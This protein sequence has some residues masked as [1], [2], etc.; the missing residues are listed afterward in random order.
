MPMNPS[1]SRCK[2]ISCAASSGDSSA[3]LMV[4]S[5]SFGCFIGIGDAGELFENSGAGFGIKTF[6]VALLAGLDRRGD[7]HQDESAHRIDQG[8]HVLAGCIVGGDG[9]ADGDASVLGDLRGDVPDAADVDVAMLFGEAQFGRKMLA[10]QI[11]IEQR[12]R[13]AAGFEK[14]GHQHIGDG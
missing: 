9:S 13:A 8:A 12:D 4:T 2:M 14:F 10:H 3:V 7:V 6:A 5:A 1:R 11:A